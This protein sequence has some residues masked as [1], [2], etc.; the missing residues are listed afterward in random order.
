MFTIIDVILLALTA[1][2]VGLGI[3]RG[4]I[5]SVARF[6]GGIVRLVLAGL[7]TKPV[8][9][10]IS[11]TAIGEHMFDKYITK[12]SLISDKFNVNLVG[13]ESGA[14]KSFVNDA[15]ADAKIPKIFRGLLRNVLDIGAENLSQYE[16][17]TLAELMGSAI[18]KIILM[19]VIFVVLTVVLFLITFFIRRWSK[20]MAGSTTIFA[21][22]N[23]VLGGALGLVQT[24]AI[25][26]VFFGIVA[27]F[28]NF[29]WFP[30]FTTYINNSFI[31]GPVYKL[32]SKFIMFLFKVSPV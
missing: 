16:S 20:R 22:T 32:I 26:F 4:F 13:M 1:L 30:A 12:A 17:I 10:L 23:K 2:C 9:E 27:I 15:L 29:G 14:L 24:F 11:K 3:Y 6:L 21:R 25:L 31:C 7:L 8:T 5:G 28:E 18:A 19:V